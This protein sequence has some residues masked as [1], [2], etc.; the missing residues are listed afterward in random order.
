MLVLLLLVTVACSSEPVFRQVN[1]ELTVHKS[2]QL[3]DQVDNSH[4]LRRYSR[5]VFLPKRDL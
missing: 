2:L 3:L 1:V 5:G 4:L